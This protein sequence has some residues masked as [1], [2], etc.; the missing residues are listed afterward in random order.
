MP[1]DIREAL[2]AY[3]RKYEKLKVGLRLLGPRAPRRGLLWAPGSTP[4]VLSR[5][6]ACVHVPSGRVRA[7]CSRGLTVLA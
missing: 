2:E 4:S 1:E 6:S 5:E 3:C 7:P